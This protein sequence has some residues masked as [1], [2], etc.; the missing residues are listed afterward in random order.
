MAFNIDKDLN[1]GRTGENFNG[2]KHEYKKLNK[3]NREENIYGTFYGDI[4]NILDP[5]EDKEDTN[6][7]HSYEQKMTEN[8]LN[9]NFVK[10]QKTQGFAPTKSEVK[11]EDKNKEEISDEEIMEEL[12]EDYSKETRESQA[13]YGNL[14]QDKKLEKTLSKKYGKGFAMLKKAGFKV[15]SGL[16]K[17]EQGITDP[18]KIKK[19]KKKMGIS[20]EDKGS[21]EDE[22]EI[23]KNPDNSVYTKKDDY[24][25][26]KKKKIIEKKKEEGRNEI[27]E[28]E[29]FLEKWSKIKH[30][31]MTTQDEFDIDELAGINI[32]LM[33]KN[34]KEVS[35]K[36]IDYYDFKKSSEEA[37]LRSQG[38]YDITKN[39]IPNFIAKNRQ[40]SI[41]ELIKQIFPSEMQ[42]NLAT[43][44]IDRQKEIL[45]TLIK[46]SK[47]KVLSH[48]S[49]LKSTED[50]SVYLRF[51]ANRLL[52]E[53]NKI[54]ND[55]QRKNNF[56][57]ELMEFS[58]IPQENLQGNNHMIISPT[59]RSHTQNI[60]KFDYILFIKNFINL[61]DNNKQEYLDNK[62]L[63]FYCIH[64]VITRMKFQ[65]NLE[66][67]MKSSNQDLITVILELIRNL[68]KKTFEETNIYEENYHPSDHI[69]SQRKKYLNDDDEEILG[70]TKVSQS[71]K[72]YGN[73]LFEIVIK[74]LI[75]YIINL[76]NVKEYEKLID[77]IKLY[78]ELIPK[79]LFD[80]IIDS[81]VI[82]RLIE[83]TNENWN[84]V[85][86]SK[87]NT[88]SE[89]GNFSLYIHLWV[90]P[91]LEILKLQKL[92]AVIKIIENKIEKNII[93]W[94]V[95][96]PDSIYILKPWR[97]LWDENYFEDMV[98]K[99][100]LPKLNFIMSKIIIDPRNQNL[101]N[102]KILF[103]WKNENILSVGKIISI[104]KKHFFP[105]WLNTLQRWLTEGEITEEKFY[106]IQKWYEGWKNYFMK[107][108]M[109]NFD[110]IKTEFK[111]AMM[112]I[113][114]FAKN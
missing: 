74:D 80:Y 61:Y 3:R 65:F 66:D 73:F 42:D 75:N 87:E 92:N 107:Q 26:G 54:F 15:G 12:L 49:S 14:S 62:E 51:E 55:S 70:N 88:S 50:S 106:E 17:D 109:M 28:F 8:Y 27:D 13:K 22:D 102:L 60:H 81:A 72:I 76:W 53:N 68:V 30:Y 83:Y 95:S 111:D 7:I 45:V 34:E 10:S 69:F 98:N 94:D 100:I 93:D 47:E 97:R 77:V 41:S 20:H 46:Y 38:K 31:I 91:W 29:Q 39:N 103:K 56:L 63:T 48:L 64:K 11:I 2:M 67:Y 25:L 101:S 4:E 19:R 40:L 71:E 89:K 114:K 84:P 9:L 16:G 52:S 86:H 36:I 90:L 105:K 37:N 21:D 24:F 99:Y 5:L 1:F 44:N 82:P 104:L 57:K 108:N 6:N 96:N 23:D 33:R 78:Q 35:L 43:E 32:G 79:F 110:E 18:I 113:F 112:L 59:N 85:I 58:D